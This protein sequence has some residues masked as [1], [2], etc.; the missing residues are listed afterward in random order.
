MRVGILK[1]D[2]VRDQ[3]RPRFGDYPDMF[4]ALFAEVAADIEFEVYDVERGEFPPSMDACDAYLITGSRWGV[5]DEHGWIPRLEQYVRE[6]HAAGRP[7]IGIC[8]GHQLIARALGGQAAKSPKGWGVGIETVNVHADAPWM[9]PPLDDLSLIVSHQ[10][11]VTDLPPGAEVLAGNEF[12]PYAVLAID[13]RILTFQGH[14]EF[15]RE[16]SRELIEMRREMLGPELAQSGLDSL[17]RE[18]HEKHAASWIV[19][20]LRE[21][22]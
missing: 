11:Q 13:G 2:S 15:A 8:F 12:C 17:R 20:F 6:L 9:S 22:T 10:D 1:C 3:F 5:Y 7:L 19:K 18:T 14:P 16:F 21:V 4:K